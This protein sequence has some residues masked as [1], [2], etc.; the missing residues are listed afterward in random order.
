M[1]RMGTPSDVADVAEYLAWDLAA[2]LSGQHLLV[3]GGAPAS[4]AEENCWQ[5][6]QQKNLKLSLIKR[7]LVLN[8]LKYVKRE[9]FQ[10]RS[11]QSFFMDSVT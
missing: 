2:F 6:S 11:E 5:I 4:V 8:S 9:S 10:F 7:I 1:Q 3:T